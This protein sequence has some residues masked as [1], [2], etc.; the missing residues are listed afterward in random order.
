MRC[1]I[2][3]VAFILAVF[4]FALTLSPAIE[5]TEIAVEQLQK[6]EMRTLKLVEVMKIDDGDEFFFKAPLQIVIAPDGSIIV[7]EG[8]KIYRFDSQGE[9]I[10]DLF[11]EGEGPG[12]MKEIGSILIIANR[13]IIYEKTKNKIIELD[14]DGDFIQE[15]KLEKKRFTDVLAYYKDK[16]YFV[17]WIPT[18]KEGIISINHNLYVVDKDGTANK[19]GLN[20]PT[21]TSLVRGRGYT[22]Y[23]IINKLI[24]ASSN[25][26]FLYIC[27]TPDYSIKL[28]DLMGI[29]IVSVLKKDYKRI[30]VDDSD[31]RK[32]WYPVE[33]H[34]DIQKL[35]LHKTKLWV[36][37]STI[38][39][40]KGILVDVYTSS[41]N[42]IDKF[43][44]P[45]KYSRLDGI[46]FWSM[47][48][49]DDDLFMF[50]E[51]EDNTLSLVKYNIPVPLK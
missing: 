11:R 13:I 19:S 40:N 16:Y 21:M 38:Q 45:I 7:N 6:N 50:K 2:I 34:N 51:N 41:G 14:M 46:L 4:I 20:F 42:L 39:K 30:K 17:D 27:H 29:E 28:L 32:K 18:G 15:K 26:R 49:S 5:L 35:L 1:L 33:F 24:W 47:T 44:L 22:S 10:E 23:Q 12:E 37:T 36:V 3:N 31:E 8:D 25:S 43:Y 48:I 9:F